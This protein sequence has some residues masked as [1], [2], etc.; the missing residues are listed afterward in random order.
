MVTTS[1]KHKKKSSK[2]LLGGTISISEFSK[3]IAGKKPQIGY[4]V[5]F[6][7]EYE[8][9]AQD[10]KKKGEVNEGERNLL[11]LI[12]PRI[13][14]SWKNTLSYSERSRFNDEAKRLIDEWKD[15]VETISQEIITRAASLPVPEGWTEIENHAASGEVTKWYHH[16]DAA[17]G[18]HSTFERPF[19]ESD[20]TSLWEESESKNK[21]KGG[22]G[23]KK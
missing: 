5:Y 18:H 2:K 12:G 20:L 22:K 16:V 6:A 8:R 23:K 13:A 3:N 19:V 15:K 11:K 1:L 17:G 21:K 9:I 14:V 4:R 7:K 10:M